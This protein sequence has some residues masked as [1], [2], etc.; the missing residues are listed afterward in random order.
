MPKVQ[1]ETV[2]RST[3]PE[4]LLFINRIRVKQ[5][6]R[7]LL[8]EYFDD[9]HWYH[10]SLTEC[11]VI[12]FELAERAGKPFV[13]LACTN[14]GASEVCEAAVR[15]KGITDEDLS[16]G[17]LCDP[18]SKSSLRIVARRGVILRLTRNF[19]KQRGFVN[20]AMV[21]VE[22]SLR[23]NEVFTARLIGS[24]NMV[25]IHPMEE[26]GGIFLPCCYGYATTIRRAQGS[27]L[28]HGC[29]YMDQMKRP[30]GRGYG[31]VGVSRFQSRAGCYLYGKL[32]RTDFLP[33]DPEDT[34]E[35]LE[36]G[37]DSVDSEDSDG[38]G[39]EA[40]GMGY[41][42]EDWEIDEECLEHQPRDFESPSPD[43]V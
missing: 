2:Y 3:D 23:G 36:R 32:R 42:N 12:G 17:Y 13:W 40:V 10:M 28:Y 33:V 4:H 6:T 31:Y 18:C 34:E 15:H 11:V 20:G 43:F 35:V 25:L 26:D 38:C 37:Y 16:N 27:D 24:G 1:L 22:D 7:P 41:S 19:D 14:R 39:M 30:A 29:L 21:C 9:R 5:P 8:E